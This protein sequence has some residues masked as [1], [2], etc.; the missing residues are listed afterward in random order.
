[1][2]VNGVDV[3]TAGMA[4]QRLADFLHDPG[5]HEPRIE[6]VAEIMKAA[7]ADA[8]AANG[9]FPSG[10]DYADGLAFERE[11][12]ALLLAFSEKELIYTVRKRDFTP[13]ATGSLR[14]AYKEQVAVEVDMFPP[15]VEELAPAH[16]RINR[17]YNNDT[18]VGSRCRKQ[19]LLLV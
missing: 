1:V 15:L 14:L 8:R 7:V 16:A 17:R 10:L 11:K 5:F 18:E 13:F 9:S 3:F 12:Q 2:G 4:H 19:L 6:R